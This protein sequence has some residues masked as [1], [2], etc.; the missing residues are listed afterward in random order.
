MTMPTEEIEKF[1]AHWEAVLLWVAIIAF[2]AFFAGEWYG[3]RSQRDYIN[4]EVSIRNAEFQAEVDASSIDHARRPDTICAT[5]YSD[6]PVNKHW[7]KRATATTSVV[8]RAVCQH[9]DEVYVLPD[10]LP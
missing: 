2:A 7:D 1:E 3:E 4:S 8:N 6:K 9:G 5:W 10:E